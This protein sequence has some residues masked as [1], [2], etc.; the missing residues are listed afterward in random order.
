MKKDKLIY[1]QCLNNHIDIKINELIIYNFLMCLQ[2]SIIVRDDLKMSKGKIMAQ[3]VH[4]TMMLFKNGDKMKI[5]KWQNLHGEKVV[6][7]R[8]NKQKIKEIQKKAIQD[9]GIES[10]WVIDAG[11]TEEE[12]TETVCIFEPIKS[13]YI[14]KLTRNIKL[15]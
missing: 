2:V 6:I 4:S 15:M 8:A 14:Q 10:Y 12:G 13:K 3:I 1:Y 7:L 5:E 11:R 9:Y